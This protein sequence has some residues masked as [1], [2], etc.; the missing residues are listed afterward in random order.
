MGMPRLKDYSGAVHYSIPFPHD[1]RLCPGCGEERTYAWLSSGRFIFQLNKLVHVQSQVVQCLTP[2]CL[3]NGQLIHPTAEWMLAPKKLS[4]GCDVIST[5]GALRMEEK[6]KLGAIHQYLVEKHGLPISERGVNKLM[7]LYLALVS[8]SQLE[9]RDLIREIQR[10][11]A[12]VLSLDAAE[13]LKGHEASWLV[14]DVLTG[15]TLV[16]RTMRSSTTADVQR[17]VHVVKEFAAECKVPIIGAVSDAGRVIRKAIALEL[18]GIPHQLCR[19]HYVKDLAKPLMDEDRELKKKLKKPFRDLRKAERTLVT[20]E[21]PSASASEQPDPAPA[22]A[23]ADVSRVQGVSLSYLEKLCLA[24]RSILKDSGHYPFKPPGLKL[25]ERLALVRET[26]RT[27]RRK[28]GG[29]CLEMLDGMLGVLDELKE[30]EEELRSLYAHIWKVGTVLYHEGQ[31][32]TKAKQQMRELVDEWNS[33]RRNGGTREGLYKSWVK[34]TDSLWPG[35]FHCYDDPR[36]PGDNNS[37]ERAIRDLK[38]FER[39]FS[40]NPNPAKRFVRHADF[41]AAFLNCKRIPG[42][43]FVASRTAEQVQK[44]KDTLK[45][46]SLKASIMSR[47]RRDTHGLLKEILEESRAGPKG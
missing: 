33:L 24:I 16:A 42:L 2:D 29:R 36:I 1:E 28:K 26:V 17:L 3:V 27:L 37:T 38:N 4:Y 10:N 46:Q 15:R 20:P 11:G 5:I 6:K 19:P 23:K 43:D 47:A 14:R 25:Y 39:H 40:Q 41:L 45:A 34:L 7:D 13:P 8:G 31:T 44:A 9:D 35:L 32:S 22:E 30:Q 21:K 18:P 12:I